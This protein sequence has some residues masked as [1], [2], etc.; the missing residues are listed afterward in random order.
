LAN[1]FASGAAP[2][3][4]FASGFLDGGAGFSYAFYKLWYF[5]TVRRLINENRRR[6]DPD[7]A[8]DHGS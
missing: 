3:R 2:S 4:T 1:F 5:E 6:R 8:T 7:E